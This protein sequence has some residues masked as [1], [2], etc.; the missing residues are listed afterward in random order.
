MCVFPR[1][2]IIV[3]DVL[4][5]RAGFRRHRPEPVG[6]TY[7]EGH[8]MP[9]TI[10]R[11]ALLHTGLGAGAAVLAGD[12]EAHAAAEMKP[13]EN[14]P[15]Q[16]P[17][18]VVQFR[19]GADLDDNVAR[20]CNHIRRCARDGTRVVV[21]P[22]C[23]V[24]GYSTK[25][26][27]PDAAQL[28]R[29]EASI[30]AAAKESAVNAIIGIPTRSGG[31]VYNSAVV[32]AP[33]GRV[34]ERYHKVHLAGEKW[35]IPGDHLSVF[36]LDGIPCSIIVCHDE[37]YPE[38]VRLPV[39]V[40]ARI[41]FYISCESGLSAPRKMGPYR[42]QIQAR[43]V[44]NGVF[45]LHAN[46]PA[47][48]ATKDG[49]HGESRIVAPDGN[50]VCEAGIYDEDTLCATLDLKLAT[51]G[52]ALQSPNSPFLRRWWEEGTALVRRVE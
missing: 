1:R 42:A 41:V 50:I 27:P 22:E 31:V 44:E 36:R 10:T 45:V 30:A 12:E 9:S 35:A 14:A 28:A 2:A 25:A 24:T 16:L 48:R 33:D 23:S 11:R 19:S 32:I 6:I 8:S 4:S 34:I 3:S 46:A 21:F 49:S 29:A 15:P 52:N 18:A 39:L 17:V 40:G 37:R 26:V 51:R 43:A 7:S 38:L 5:H 13:A 47:D 20:H